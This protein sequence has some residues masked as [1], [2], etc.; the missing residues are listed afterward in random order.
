MAGGSCRQDAARQ[1]GRSN[2][3]VGRAQVARCLADAEGPKSGGPRARARA[4][5]LRDLEPAITG[6]VDG[7]AIWC[8]L[9]L[10]YEIGSLYDGEKNVLFLKSEVMP[11]YFVV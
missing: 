8:L 7:G 1:V 5:E 2:S 4:T 9:Q 3:C 10:N 6:S 11:V